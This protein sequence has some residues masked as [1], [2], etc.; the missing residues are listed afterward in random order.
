[1]AKLLGLRA[2]EGGDTVL[3]QE[4]AWREN[5]KDFSQAS[6]SLRTAKSGLSA[7]LPD[8][9]LMAGGGTRKFAGSFR[10]P[11]YCMRPANL[12][13]KDATGGQLCAG[14]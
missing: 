11:S 3:D 7:C 2:R 9:L 12:V 1:M 10:S 14:Q 8:V 6:L 5:V 4:F 13:W